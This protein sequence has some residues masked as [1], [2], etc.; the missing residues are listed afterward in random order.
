MRSACKES[1]QLETE[2]FQPLAG[3]GTLYAYSTNRFW[4]QIKHAAAVIYANRQ[5][6]AMYRRT[7]PQRLVKDTCPEP[8]L[9]DE[10][11]QDGD[12]SDGPRIIGDV[13]V[14]ETSKVD[15]TAVLCFATSTNQICPSPQTT[16]FFVPILR[17]LG[18]DSV[19]IAF[20]C[21]NAH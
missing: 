18:S 3:S 19:G 5:V 4:S 9:R 17:Y 11:K 1:I 14:H 20:R 12:S 6:L 8:N 7:H 13:C 10:V 16:V 21:R 2:I 15:K